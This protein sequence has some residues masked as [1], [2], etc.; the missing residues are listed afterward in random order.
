MI[1]RDEFFQ[2]QQTLLAHCHESAI[3]VIPAA[4]MQRRSRDTHYAFRQ[5][6]DFWYLLG[7]NE[8]DAWLVL[9]NH[10]RLGANFSGL[11]CRDKH[12][13]EERWHGR[14]LG[15]TAARTSLAVQQ[16]HAIDNVAQQLYDLMQG[17]EHLYFALGEDSD[18]DQ[19]VLKVL[20]R[21][22]NVPKTQLAPPCI[23]DIRPLLHHQRLFKSAAELAL[24]R[25]AARITA[26]GHCRAM[27]FTSPGCYEYQIEAEIRHE[28][29]IHGA[30]SSAYQ[31]IVGSAENA[32]ILHYTDNSRQCH[33][34]E[35]VLIDAGAEWHGYAADITRT[36]PVSGR[37]SSAQKDLYQLVLASQQTAL[38]NIGPGKLLT[39]AYESC[40][41]VLT[42]GLLDLGILKGT[43]AQHLE[44]KSYRAYF[45]HG[46][47][48]YLGLDVHDVGHY[49]CDNREVPLAQNM[50]ITI[51]PGLYID[52]DAAVP[53][54]FRG[55][56]IRIEDDVVITADGI[57]ILTE[58]VPKT[59]EGIE[60]LMQGAA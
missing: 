20:E 9:S 6:S 57:D 52:A 19:V 36:F 8:P 40:V 59:I 31:S 11:L 17:H 41:Q 26:K 27:H 16:A 15:P 54:A 24:M 18:N 28:F 47:G 25:E 42:E 29:A 43:V 3:C 12:P 38:A 10:P 5:H 55:I 48:H 51:E 34:G 53:E 50:V 56:G 7:F 33:A 60:A 49:R 14:R 32:C 21:L 45:M 2:R 46:L 35:L 23:Q 22:R 30:R 37:F 1:T 58:A 4:R 39:D 13:E 44:Q